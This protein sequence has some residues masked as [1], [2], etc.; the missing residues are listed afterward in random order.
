MKSGSTPQTAD[1][2]A[3]LKTPDVNDMELQLQQLVEQG[4]LS[5]EEAHAELLN[6]SEMNKISLDPRTKEAQMAALSGLQDVADDGLTTADEAA[7]SRIRN[8]ENTAARGQREA[9]LQNAQARGMGGSG[10]ELLANLKNQQDSATRASQRDLDV[11]GQSQQRALQALIQSGQLG[12]QI[13]AQDFGQQAQIAGAN[14]AIAKFNA[15]VQNQMN[16]A[17]VNARNQA[18]AQNLENRQNIANQNVQLNNQQQQYNKNLAQQNFENQLKKRSGQAGIAQANAQAQGQ[19]SQNQANAWNQTIG[20]VAGVGSAALAR[21]K[22]GGMV[23]GD[24]VGYDGEP[25]LL[26]SGE[27]VVRK[28]DVPHVLK[29]A[30][31]DDDGEFDAAGFL[32]AIT[33]HKYGYAK[34]GKKNA[35]K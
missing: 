10:L 30:Y 9:I 4:V 2:F 33:G 24:S 31:T 19:N 18:Q 20:T 6:Q 26:E 12:G 3:D 21:K 7:L 11:A 14:D 5:P 34:K 23:G 8:E 22:D 32:D 16:M 15:D 17:N 29:K 25:H 27:F 35:H 13:Q 1:Y 28:E